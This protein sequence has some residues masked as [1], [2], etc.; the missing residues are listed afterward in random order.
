VRNEKLEA[1]IPGD[2]KRTHAYSAIFAVHARAAAAR[3][4]AAC[5]TIDIHNCKQSAVYAFLWLR[6]PT[7]LKDSHK[8]NNC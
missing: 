1:A 4:Q 5:P 8:Q 7:D 2:L 6:Q 3:T